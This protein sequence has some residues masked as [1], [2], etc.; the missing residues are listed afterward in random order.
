MD[1]HE[2]IAEALL[3]AVFEQGNIVRHADR[4]PSWFTDNVELSKS[5][6]L[7]LATVGLVI[8]KKDIITG[9]DFLVGKAGEPA[10]ADKIIEQVWSN[11]K[12]DQLRKE[13]SDNSIFLTVPSTT[14]AN[15]IPI[16]FA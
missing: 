11:K 12:T 9:P 1:T 13:L 4:F 6:A 15:V 10:A 3:N 16:Q 14:R 8:I 7:G 5:N 2:Q